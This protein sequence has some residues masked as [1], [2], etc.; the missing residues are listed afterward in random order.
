MLASGWQVLTIATVR[1]PEGRPDDLGLSAAPRPFPQHH[2][3]VECLVHNLGGLARRDTLLA[4]GHA[5]LVGAE[6]SG[7]RRDRRF[8]HR[9]HCLSNASDHD[10]DGVRF[11]GGVRLVTRWFHH[12]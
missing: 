6:G 4:A 12:L 2:S 5:A 7:R 11:R 3:L 8:S 1:T 10:R 9:R